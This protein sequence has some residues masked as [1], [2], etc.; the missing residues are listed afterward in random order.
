MKETTSF[1]FPPSFGFV[2]IC[3]SPP[4]ALSPHAA[5]GCRGQIHLRRFKRAPSMTCTSLTPPASCLPPDTPELSRLL[6]PLLIYSVKLQPLS[7][8]VKFSSKG[9]FDSAGT[10]FERR[11][12]IFH[13]I[14]LNVSLKF[15]I[16][17]CGLSGSTRVQDG[18]VERSKTHLLR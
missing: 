16:F 7:L 14:F 9:R 2:S 1:L 4:S 5:T 13:T 11:S 12:D 18:P 8:E 10:R 6:R 17:Q 3:S 15:S